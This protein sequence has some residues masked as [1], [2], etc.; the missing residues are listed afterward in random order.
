MKVVA[1]LVFLMSSVAF[2]QGD[3]LQGEQ[4]AAKC[5]SCHGEKGI[6]AQP[7]HPNLAGQN[8]RYLLWQLHSFKADKRIGHHMNDIAKGLTDQDIEDLAVYYSQLSS[9]Q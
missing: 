2:A 4:I 6:A 9:C 8:E 7:M 3:F 1:V 5:V